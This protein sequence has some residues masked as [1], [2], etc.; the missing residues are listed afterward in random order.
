MVYLVFAHS[1]SAKQHLK[2][3]SWWKYLTC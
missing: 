3:L 1:N 2:S